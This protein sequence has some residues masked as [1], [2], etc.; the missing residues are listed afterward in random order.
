H[1]T[2]V[3]TCALP[4][5]LVYHSDCVSRDIPNL[6]AL[7]EHCAGVMAI[8]ISRIHAHYLIWFRRE[9]VKTVEWAGKPEKQVDRHSG[10]LS[11]RHSFERWQQILGGYAQP[12]EP[13]EIEGALELRN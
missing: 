12:W 3:Q 7:A 9:Q 2:G 4:I 8:S 5:C 6:P 1:V 11:P 10:A 13:V